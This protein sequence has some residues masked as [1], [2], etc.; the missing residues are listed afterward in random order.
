MSQLPCGFENVTA[1]LV[2]A[3]RVPLDCRI[4][5]ARVGF[6]AEGVNATPAMPTPTC[7][8][9]VAVKMMRADCFAKSREEATAAPS[10]LVTGFTSTRTFVL[11]VAAPEPIKTEYVPAVG[12][13]GRWIVGR[14][15]PV[16]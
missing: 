15:V 9:A 12:R 6:P 2:D 8:P 4:L 14:L 7:W 3:T 16:M 10:M 1:Q 13:R 5:T 11:S